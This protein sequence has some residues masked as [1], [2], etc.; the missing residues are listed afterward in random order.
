M[1]KNQGC[2]VLCGGDAGVTFTEHESKLVAKRIKQ[3]Y[4]VHL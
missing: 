2:S 3:G 1:K 4:N